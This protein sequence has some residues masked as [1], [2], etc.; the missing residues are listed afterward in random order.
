MGNVYLNNKDSKNARN[1]FTNALNIQTKF[2]GE[3]STEL[4]PL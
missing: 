3:N 2:L 4:I 1:A